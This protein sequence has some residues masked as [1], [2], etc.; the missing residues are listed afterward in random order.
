[1]LI[2]T[3]DKDNLDPS[4]I[5]ELNWY[6]AESPGW[7]QPTTIIIDMIDNGERGSINNYE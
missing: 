7:K 2:A 3:G 6:D 1:M 5:N 4:G